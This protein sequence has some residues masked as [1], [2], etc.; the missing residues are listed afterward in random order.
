MTR[1]QA[2][3]LLQKHLQTP[4]L[5]NHSLAVEAIMRGLARRLKEDE[6]IYGL[7]GLLHD[8]DYDTT[9]ED[10]QQ[11][12]LV[13]ASILEEN[14]LPAEVVYA[15]KVHN[16]CHG[17][18]RKSQLDK[19]LYAADPVSGFITAAALVRPDKK[20]AGVQLKS[21]RKRFKEASFAR[22][23]NREQMAA[24]AELGLELD[25]FLTI[26]LESMQ[27]IAGELGL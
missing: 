14:G 9:G 8:I 13:G 4:N 25:E 7:A 6:E 26:A 5:V 24:C 23:A 18:E 16:E 10:P 21:L 1:E 22:G 27:G 17:L 11:H 19:A 12:S 20:L 3:E 15:V 2:W